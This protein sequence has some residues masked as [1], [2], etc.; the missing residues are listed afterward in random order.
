MLALLVL[1]A[2]MLWRSE[3]EAGSELARLLA[4]KATRGTALSAIRQSEEKRKLLLEWTR[5]PP[6]DIERRDELYLGMI[7]VFAVLREKAA[8]PFLIEKI[9]LRSIDRPN[10]WIRPSRVIVAESPAIQALLRMGPECFPNLV[11]GYFASRNLK[12]RTAILFT[13]SRLNVPAAR[14]FLEDVAYHGHL[15]LCDAED[16]LARLGE[17]HDRLCRPATQQQTPSRPK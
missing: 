5:K 2:G 1:M 15:E 17:R 9:D 10:L 6:P 11:E 12:Q 4:D 14:R 3:V 16:G 13:I 8:V 7:E